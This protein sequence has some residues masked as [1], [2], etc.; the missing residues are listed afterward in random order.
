[1]STLERLKVSSTTTLTPEEDEED[2]GPVIGP[3][4][5]YTM[6]PMEILLVVLLFLIWFYALR[7]FYKVWS[8][9]LN[10]SDLHVAD[11]MMQRGKGNNI[12]I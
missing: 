7:R 10:F 6:G 11:T 8:T 4:P 9:V 12:P 3:Y 5:S 1:M 2:I